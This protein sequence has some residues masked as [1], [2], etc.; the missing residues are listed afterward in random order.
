MAMP[1]MRWSGSHPVE[2]DAGNWGM[3]R[4]PDPRDYQVPPPPENDSLQTR[5]ELTELRK[6]T[7]R[8]S[9]TDVEEILYWS[10][11]EPSAPTHWER[12]ADQ[13]IRQYG[14][15]VPAGA[16]I[17]F[18]LTAAIHC[19]LVACWHEKYHYLRPR[20]PQLD[21][22]ID[23]SVI[24]LPDH[25][26]YPSGHSTAAG[27]A[28]RLLR[29]FFPNERERLKAMAEQAGLSRLKAGIHY[30]SDHEAGLDLGSAVAR[31]LVE[32]ADR[33]GAPPWYE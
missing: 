17:Q 4:L 8:R 14:L 18:M 9:S 2:P 32:E 5:A 19:A 29:S 13:L 6:L 23:V 30:R 16:R 22:A 1:E 15:S 31:Q 12:T 10:V 20:P 25:P 21:Q 33:D 24:P 26:S 27:A 7:G 3:I 28:Y 11:R